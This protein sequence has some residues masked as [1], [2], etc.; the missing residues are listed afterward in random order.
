MSPKVVEI[1]D[2]TVKYGSFTAVEGVSFSLGKGTFGLLGRN[3]AGKTT[4]LRA[5]LGLVRPSG[6]SLRVLG[7]DAASDPLAVRARVGYLP[8]GQVFFPGMTGFQAVAFA[9]RLS[10]LSRRV[11]RK[12]AHEMLYFAGLGEARYRPMEGYSTGMLQRVKLAMALV[13]DPP[14]LFLDE[15]TNGL[16]PAGRKQML[17]RVRDLA[18]AKGKTLILSSHILSD[19][20]AVC[21][22]AL[23]LH[24]GRVLERGLL[25]ELTSAAPSVREVLAAGEESSLR[26]ALEEQGIS[27]LR[28]ERAGPF[29]KFRVG[30]PPGAGGREIFLAV[31]KGGGVVR[32]LVEA[33]R[34][35][36]E[37]FGETV[38]GEV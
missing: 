5:L 14:L 30:L 10:G 38:G 34:S 33:R 17:E 22:E 18:S 20:E 4:I 16:D 2:L 24:E 15:P 31:S 11:A 29:L 19:V 13:H 32:S 6:G 25:G 3:G 1:R 35:L 12:R 7:L 9:G 8:E 27:V 37:V 36:E 28:V 21:D 23:L 26:A